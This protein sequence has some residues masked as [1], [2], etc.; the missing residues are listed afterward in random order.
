MSYRYI[1][2]DDA[3]F[4]V[5]LIK[6]ILKGAGGLCVGDATNGEEGLHLFEKTL[7]DLVILDLVMPKKNGIEVAAEIR[8][9]SGDVKIIACSTLDEKN[10][11][12]KALTA[13]CDEYLLKPF[14]KESVLRAVSRFF[15]I[16]SE[17]SHE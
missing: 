6:N 3:P 7:P 10:I 16:T 2:I 1:V 4:V 9:L 5:E 15:S 17:K 13:G 11:M 14:S 8:A 12:E